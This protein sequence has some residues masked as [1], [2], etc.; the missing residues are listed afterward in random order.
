[1]TKKTYAAGDKIVIKKGKGLHYI[2]GLPGVIVRQYIPNPRFYV[3][4]FESGTKL[5]VNSKFFV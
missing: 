2:G 4:A 5:L 3:V 1:M